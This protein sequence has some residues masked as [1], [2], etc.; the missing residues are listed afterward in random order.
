[1]E[2]EGSNLS[3]D[4]ARTSRWQLVDVDEETLVRIAWVEGEH[5]VV[6][7]LLKAGALIA[8]SQGAASGS[9]KQAGLDALGLSIVSDVLNDDSPFSIDVLSAQGTSVGDI[10]WAD[11]SLTSNP[12]AFVELLAVIEG[13]VEFLLLLLCDSINQI[14]G[15]LVSNIG[16]LLQDQRIIIDG[17][18]DFVGGVLAIG[19]APGESGVFGAFRGGLWITVIVFLV[20]WVSWVG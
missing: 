10:R 14:I 9:S 6:D 16:V 18:L 12:V 11:K 13:I 17:I 7:I 8:R 5:A 2:L 3:W 20:G 4:V 19:Q 15:R 1:M